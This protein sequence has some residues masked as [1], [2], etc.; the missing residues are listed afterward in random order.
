L[1]VR[2]E[3]TAPVEQLAQDERDRSLGNDLVRPGDRTER[4]VPPSSWPESPEFA[5]ERHLLVA[6][7]G[8]GHNVAATEVRDGGLVIDFSAM[9]GLWIDPAGRTARAQPGTP[10]GRVR[11]HPARRPVILQIAGDLKQN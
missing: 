6:V 4:A 10:L 8:G 9:K 11:P 3:A 2:A 7:R 1:H 5:R